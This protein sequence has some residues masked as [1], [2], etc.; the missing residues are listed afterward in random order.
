MFCSQGIDLKESGVFDEGGYRSSWSS[1]IPH[2]TFLRH[3][4]K[5]LRGT[6]KIA[7]F[8]K[9]ISNNSTLLRWSFPNCFIMQGSKHVGLVAQEQFQEFQGLLKQLQ[10]WNQCLMTHLPHLAYKLSIPNYLIN[11]NEFAQQ[12]HGLQKPGLNYTLHERLYVPAT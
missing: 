10:H 9:K 4:S 12:D 1:M 6:I 3:S 11:P 7:Q 8:K 5:I 2:Y